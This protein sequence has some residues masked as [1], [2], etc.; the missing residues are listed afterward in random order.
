MLNLPR[1]FDQ[2]NALTLKNFSKIKHHAKSLQIE[3]K[4]SGRMSKLIDIRNS[5]AEYLGFKDWEE[6][7]RVFKELQKNLPN[8]PT[9]DELL[10]KEQ[11]SNLVDANR[12]SLAHWGIEY[13][14]FEP[15]RVALTKGIID[16]THPVRDL[17][18][19]ENFHSYYEQSQGPD[20]KVVK[21]AKMISNNEI[22]ATTISMYR[23]V[24]KDGDPRMWI[25]GLPRF[26]DPWSQIGIIIDDDTACIIDLGVENL[27]VSYEKNDTI[28]QFLAAHLAKKNSVSNE[29]LAKLKQLASQPI[30]AVTKGDTAIGMSIEAALGIP[31]NSS[32]QPDY[33]GIELKAS[34]TPKNRTNLFAQVPIWS[35]SNLKSSKE[36]LEK[37][38]YPGKYKLQL[39]CTVSAKVFNSQGLT[40]KYDP[41]TDILTEA[42]ITGFE[43]VK[44]TGDIL[45]NRL[46]EKHA[47]TFWIQADS[48]IID[49]VEYFTIKSVTHTK[50]PLKSQLMLLIEDGTITM[51]HLIKLDG[52]SVTEKGPLFKINKKHLPLLFPDPVTHQF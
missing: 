38:G 45:R 30:K 44:W 10:K 32:K 7:E 21:P 15:T 26:A 18:S 36:I 41:E 40:F 29:L 11:L 51:D 19:I 17:F 27:E 8:T 16:A 1:G 48:K 34:R 6:Y 47:E 24:S 50:S 42:D 28:G 46:L 37:Y 5:F 39:N 2:S 25:S 12:K 22:E 4:Q 43:A 13:S 35:I 31:P 14:I 20:F 23:P 49:G 3:Y 52:S 9:T 33:Q